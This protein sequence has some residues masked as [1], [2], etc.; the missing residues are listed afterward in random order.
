[1][2]PRLVSASNATNV[3]FEEGDRLVLMQSVADAAAGKPVEMIWD[4]LFT[5]LQAENDLVLQIDRGSIGITK[6]TIYD[7]VGEKPVEIKAF[8][9]SGVT[10][11]RNSYIVTIPAD[12]LLDST[13]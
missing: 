5:G 11:D 13:P 2:R 6:V 12:L 7:Y 9:W 1:M 8:E 3:G 10:Q 4:V